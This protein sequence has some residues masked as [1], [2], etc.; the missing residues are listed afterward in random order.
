[1]MVLLIGATV[2]GAPRPLEAQGESSIRVSARV[3]SPGPSIP[4]LWRALLDDVRVQAYW[5]EVPPQ[6]AVRRIAATRLV[7][8]DGEIIIDARRV[9]LVRIPPEPRTQVR[10]RVRLT[11]AFIAN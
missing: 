2:A 11:M 1:M 8:V 3:V 6:P 10:R 7:T 4:G 9:A 5:R